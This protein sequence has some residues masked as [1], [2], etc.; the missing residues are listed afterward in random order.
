MMR[1]LFVVTLLAAQ[2]LSSATIAVAQ[3]ATGSIVYRGGSGPIAVEIK[4]AFLLKGPDQQSGLVVRR[5]IFS[6][7][8]LGAALR[9]CF[10]MAS[11]FDGGLRDG[12]S[13]TLDVLPVLPFWFVTQ[14]QRVQYSGLAD[15]GTIELTT[16][17]PERLA[18]RWSLPMTRTDGLSFDLR[19]DAV[20]TKELAK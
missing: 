7:I 8:D 17:T 9:G 2:L 14:D 4:H 18:G 13:V 1:Q 6:S 16:D 19:F 5:L 3:S 11:C 12:I 20:L 10:A 15:R